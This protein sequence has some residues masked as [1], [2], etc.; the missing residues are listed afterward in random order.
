MHAVLRLILTE[1]PSLRRHVAAESP[2]LPIRK[3]PV[4]RTRI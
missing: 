1:F 2:I 3:L 4:P